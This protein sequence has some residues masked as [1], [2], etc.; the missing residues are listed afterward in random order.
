VDILKVVGKDGLRILLQLL[1]NLYETG[2]CPKDYTEFTMIALN[3][4]SNAT[5]C[6]ENCTISL[7]AYTVKIVAKILRSRIEM[8]IEDI[9]EEDQF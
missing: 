3:M 2:D 8:I 9:F 7:I 6:N 4:K 1:N 5:K